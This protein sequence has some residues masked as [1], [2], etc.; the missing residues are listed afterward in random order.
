[1]K[2]G[3]YKDTKKDRDEFVVR[4]RKKEVIID[5]R[6]YEIWKCRIKDFRGLNK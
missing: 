2:V 1:M 4:Q 6:N 5:K 3:P